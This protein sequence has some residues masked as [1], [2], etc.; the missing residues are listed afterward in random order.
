DVRGDIQDVP[1]VANLLV[2]GGS[3]GTASSSTTN[4]FSTAPRLLHI[5]DV[6]N[7]TDSF[8]T[9]RVFAYSQGVPCVELDVQKSAGTSEVE[10]S[11]RVLRELPLLR[12]T[13][14][15]VQ[16]SV[17][18]VQSTY[19]E[20][21]LQGVVR[22]LVEAILFT[23]IVM[24]FFLRSWRNAIVVMIAIPSSLLVTLAAMQLAHFTLDTVSLLAM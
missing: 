8:E 23:G 22:T 3:S 10:T 12:R 9:Q 17:L 4:V 1:T 7:V 18:N 14:P 15:D 20:Q 24:L 19:T 13:Y 21:Q 16:F 2:S 11:R 6:A 5:K